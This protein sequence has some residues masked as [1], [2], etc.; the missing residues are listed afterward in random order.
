MEEYEYDAVLQASYP[1]E[2]EY[3]VEEEDISLCA[4]PGQPSLYC[5]LL[6]WLAVL[7]ARVACAGRTR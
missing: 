6:K 5:D 3:M 4:V 1:D 2:Y 7:C